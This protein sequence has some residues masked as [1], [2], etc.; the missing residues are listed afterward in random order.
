MAETR[1]HEHEGRPMGEA[2]TY[3][4]EDGVV[5]LVIDRSEARNAINR[6]VADGLWAGFRRFEADPEAAV[7]VLTGAGDAF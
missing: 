4:L 5:W 3:A 6:A 1:T 2:V 7:L